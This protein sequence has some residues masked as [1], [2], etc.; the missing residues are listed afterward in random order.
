MRTFANHAN[1][2]DEQIGS[3]TEKM[4]RSLFISGVPC[5]GKTWLGSWL[6]EHEGFIH[7]DAEKNNGSDL[8]KAGIP[9]EWDL[10]LKSGPPKVCGLACLE[11]PS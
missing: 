10:A 3:I 11:L 5:T 1:P 8:D 6:A 4:I 7:V 9:H 2:K